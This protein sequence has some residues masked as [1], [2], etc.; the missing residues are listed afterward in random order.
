MNIQGWFPLG[1]IG[2][3]SLQS[4]GLSRVFFQQHNC[5]ASI[6]QYSAFFMVQLSHLYMTTW[7]SVSKVID[8]ST[9]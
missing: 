2:V 5:K 7:T 6:N 4:K 8:A 3:I 9:F 1:L